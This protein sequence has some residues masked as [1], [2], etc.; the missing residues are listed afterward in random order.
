MNFRRAARRV[1]IKRPARRE[2]KIER[3]LQAKSASATSDR[4]PA[5]KQWNG[6]D[7]DSP[8]S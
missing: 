4:V 7:L 2:I 1:F 8:V 6:R 3:R 5:I